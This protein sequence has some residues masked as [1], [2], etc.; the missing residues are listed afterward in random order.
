MLLIQQFDSVQQSCNS[1][2]DNVKGTWTTLPQESNMCF[3]G[4]TKRWRFM[5]AMS[6]NLSLNETR[7]D[8]RMMSYDI[9]CRISQGGGGNFQIFGISGIHACRELLLGGFGGMH[10]QENF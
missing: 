4:M 5:D 2:Y 1:I 6:M 10:P 8:E 3:S 9:L 7:H